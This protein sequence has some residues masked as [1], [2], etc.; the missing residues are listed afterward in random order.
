MLDQQFVYFPAEWIERNWRQV[1]GLPLEEVWIPVGPDVRVFGWYVEAGPAN[2]LLLWCH[3]NAG[4]IAHRLENLRDLYR[5]GLSVFLF[6]YRG[7]GKSTGTPSESGL[8][9]DALAPYDYLISE[10]GVVPERLVLFGRSLGAAVAGEVATQRPAAG[11]ILESAFPSMQSMADEHYLGFP[12]NWF[13]DAEYHLSQKLANVTIPTCVIHGEHDEIVPLALGQQVYKSARQPK[14]WYM[15]PRAGHNDVPYIGGRPY[16]RQI[17]S[18]IQ[19]VV[20]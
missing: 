19:K 10:R 9:A 11:L 16:Y 5:G 8:Y 18:F 3:G 6:D 15:V 2:P 20:R 1:S 13:V 14:T 7:Y 12:A 17:F 4:N